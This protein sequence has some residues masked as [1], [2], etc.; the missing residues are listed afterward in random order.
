M[1]FLVWHVR[2]CAGCR[3]KVWGLGWNARDSQASS[4]LVLRVSGAEKLWFMGWGLQG[5]TWPATQ[6]AEAA[7]VTSKT[8]CMHC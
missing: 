6:L 4:G 3:V 1:E 2:L 5:W 8:H 7:I